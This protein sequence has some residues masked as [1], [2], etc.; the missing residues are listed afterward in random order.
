RPRR[1]AVI[2]KIGPATTAAGRTVVMAHARWRALVVLAA[3]HALRDLCD[4]H[5]AGI[6]RAW[7]FLTT[8]GPGGQR[9]PRGLG[10]QRDPHALGR[11]PP[12]RGA[13]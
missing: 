3:L 7:F 5:R 12:A 6:T 8:V 2:A 9:D 4:G 1:R 10:G 13:S 11:R